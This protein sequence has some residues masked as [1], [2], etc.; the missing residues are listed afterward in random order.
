MDYKKV[1]KK[2][3]KYSAISI[4]IIICLAALIIYIIFDMIVSDMDS[5]LNTK[6][7]DSKEWKLARTEKGEDGLTKDLER[8]CG[9]YHD[10]TSNYL[11]KGMTIKEVEDLL[12]PIDEWSYCK[13]KKIKCKNYGM[14]VCYSNA[15]SIVPMSVFACFNE[16]GKLVTYD[17]DQHCE[18]KGS[19][20]LKT[21]EQSCLKSGPNGIGIVTDKCDLDIW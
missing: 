8:R 19:Y 5:V 13:D 3:I 20:D 11:H 9:M 14:G 4:A 15:L 6:K 18:I 21:K 17:Q 7:F 1:L 2:V 16:E 12:G 10:L